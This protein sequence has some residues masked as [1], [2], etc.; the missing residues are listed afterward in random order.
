MDVD[1]IR[2]RLRSLANPTY[3]AG[4]QNF[5]K[6]PVDPYGIKAEVIRALAREFAV[7]LKCHPLAERTA[8]CEALWNGGRFEEGG[9]AVEMHRRWL[10]ECGPAE[11]TRF[12]RWL[13]RYASNWAHCDCICMYLTSPLVER[14]PKLLTQLPAWTHSRHRWKRRGAAV[15]L[16]R[17]ARRGRNLPAI[18]EIA[19]PLLDDPDEM[20][21]KGAGWLLKE[22][23][24]THGEPV[25]QFLLAHQARAPRLVLRYAAEKMTPADRERVLGR[26]P[27]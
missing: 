4:A 25:V 14:Y 20:V 8:L 24:P 12:G 21:Q 11:F 7:A 6:D 22:A 1:A 3:A 5:F 13:V 23:Y 17:E 9:L 2:S 10:K 16:T 19:E 18:L 27:R 26:K 15:T